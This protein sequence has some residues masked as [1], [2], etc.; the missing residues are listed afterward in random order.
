MEVFGSFVKKNG[1]R[2]FLQKGA[3]IFVPIKINDV[4]HYSG[5]PLSL[6]R[7]RATSGR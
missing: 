2:L 5:V 3:K 4:I 1:K 6:P 7:S